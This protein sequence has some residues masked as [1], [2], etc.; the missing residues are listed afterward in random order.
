MQALIL[1]NPLPLF[2]LHMSLFMSSLSYKASCIVINFLIIW[3]ICQNYFRFK[4]GPQYTARW[5]ALLLI[6]LMGFLLQIFVWK[7]FL[8]HLRYFYLIFSFIA[9]C[10]MVSTTR[11]PQYFPFL[12]TFLFFP[13][14]DV[15]FIPLFVF[16]HFS[17]RVW[18]IF[19]YQT[20]FLYPGS[21]F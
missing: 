10:L 15:L 5:T 2:F 14:L 21:I 3:S 9:T 4:N 17:F 13:E 18:Y 8:V 7:T 19:L 6:L 1:E 11:I 16:F 20:P 12:Q